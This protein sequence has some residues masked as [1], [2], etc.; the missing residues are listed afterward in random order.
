MIQEATVVS[1]IQKVARGKMNE[2]IAYTIE[3][4]K[5]K[6]DAERERKKQSY[7]VQQKQ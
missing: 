3:Q 6:R 4:A 1:M 2:C 7:L 5:V